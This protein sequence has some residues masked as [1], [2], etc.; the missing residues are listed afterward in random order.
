VEPSGLQRLLRQIA[1]TD[2]EEISCSECF[3][4]ASQCTDF[5]VGG[6]T[7]ERMLP[8]LRQH[9]QQCGVCREEYE[10]LRDFARLEAEGR[11]PSDADLRNSFGAPQS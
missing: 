8:R 4:I 7:D 10:I 11:A 3:D 9:L 6:T 1:R 5:E 2:R